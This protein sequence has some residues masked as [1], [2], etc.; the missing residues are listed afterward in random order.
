MTVEAVNAWLIS[1]WIFCSVS[2]TMFA[3]ASSSSTTFS[4]EELRDKCKSI[5]FPQHLDSN[6]SHLFQIKDRLPVSKDL[7]Y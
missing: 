1:C 4:C 2:M 7:F 6:H 3:V 5:V